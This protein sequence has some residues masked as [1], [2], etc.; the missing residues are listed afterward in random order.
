VQSLVSAIRSG[1]AR[2]SNPHPI[3]H[4]VP[5]LQSV[6]LSFQFRR[7]GKYVSSVIVTGQL[8]SDPPR[9][10][11]GLALSL[12]LPLIAHQVPACE[13]SGNEDCEA[14]LPCKFADQRLETKLNRSRRFAQGDSGFP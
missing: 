9:L 1:D 2:Q 8:G 14:R 3:P 4:G 12:Y 5:A 10:R 13:T 7:E 11:R 6:G